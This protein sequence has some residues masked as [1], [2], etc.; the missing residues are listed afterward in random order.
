MTVATYPFIQDIVRDED[1][2]VFSKNPSQKHN[3]LA[4]QWLMGERLLIGKEIL[5]KSSSLSVSIHSSINLSSEYFETENS[6]G[7][8]EIFFEDYG[9]A[10]PKRISKIVV[11]VIHKGKAKIHFNLDE[12]F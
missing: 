6:I 10:T 11:G 8:D 1:F 4:F 5:D 7:F 12:E 9:L 2:G 3:L